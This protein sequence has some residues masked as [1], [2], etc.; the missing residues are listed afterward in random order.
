MATATSQPN[1]TQQTYQQPTDEQ[2]NRRL[3]DEVI[4]KTKVDIPFTKN[5]FEP[6]SLD[7]LWRLATIYLNAGL[8]PPDLTKN[9][10]REAAIAKIVVAIEYG[11]SVGLRASQAIQSV[12]VING[13]PTI[14]GDAM[15]AVCIASEC[16]AGIEE[17]PHGDG[18]Q[19]GYTC[20]ARRKGSPDVVQTFT[21]ADAKQ[22]RL[23]SK[24]GPWSTNPKR[25]LQLRARAFAL[26]DQYPDVLK[27]LSMREEVEDY[28]PAASGNAPMA[29]NR[30]AEHLASV[31]SVPKVEHPASEPQSAGIADTDGPQHDTTDSQP[32]PAAPELADP[33]GMLGRVV[34]MLSEAT[35]ISHVNA[36][37]A[38]VKAPE[39][40]APPDVRARGI[41]LCDEARERIKSK[42]GANSNK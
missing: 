16:C 20:V 25:M 42:R 22:A 8:V 39:N 9:C 18:E 2:S 3:L 35:M 15:K 19:F 30:L 27:G 41:E 26:R 11:L 17:R 21:V 14:W 4:E 36:A 37:E 13:R 10:S 7:G 6:D 32:E 38:Y 5:G 28:A 24:T 23:W 29:P 12:A 31:G 40:D 1:G 34:E 33:T